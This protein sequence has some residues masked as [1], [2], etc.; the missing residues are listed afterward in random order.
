MR[1]ADEG[2]HPPAAEPGWEEA[3]SFDWAAPD[4]SVGGAVRLALHPHDGVA[5]Y[6]GC[7]VGEGRRPAMVVDHDVRV[8]AGRSLE[9]RAEGLWADHVCETPFDHWTL[10]AEAF[11]VALDDPLDAWGQAW[12]DRVPFGI[13][14]EWE[15]DGATR[16][17]PGGYA[18]PCRVTGRV[19]VGD[20]HVEVDGSGWRSHTWGGSDR[21]STPWWSL[22][23]RVDGGPDLWGTGPLADPAPGLP[24]PDRLTV[25]GGVVAV[26]PVAFAPVLVAGP[27]GRRSLLARALCRVD[28]GGRPGRGWAEW[29]RPA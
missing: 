9:I 17:G 29:N 10:G 19:I 4:A 24:G 13:D 25:D 6:W 15:T 14:L 12:G 1:P 21:W 8:P 23:A 11:A 20:E 28:A 7:V 22:A 18:M 27:G 2:R 3:W 16:P 5:W 26:E